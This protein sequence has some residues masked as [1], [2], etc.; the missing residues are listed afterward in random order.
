MADVEWATQRKYIPSLEIKKHRLD[1]SLGRN[2][3]GQTECQMGSRTGSPLDSSSAVSGVLKYPSSS[4]S[5]QHLLAMTCQKEREGGKD[6]FLSFWL[7]TENTSPVK[8]KPKRVNIV[9]RNSSNTTD[10]VGHISSQIYKSANNVSM[11]KW[12]PHSKLAQIF[13]S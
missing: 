11:V 9:H 6:V 7:G 12:F 2:V 5:L 3:V 13:E 1:H 4:K 10:K 8:T